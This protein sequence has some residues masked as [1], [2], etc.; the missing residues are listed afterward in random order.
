L[1]VAGTTN[2]LAIGLA[3]YAVGLA[4]YG[5]AA[6]TI[7]LSPTWSVRLDLLGGSTAPRRPV[8]G[9]Q[10]QSEKQTLTAWGAGFVAALAGVEATF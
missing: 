10:T 9:V 6:G 4:V 5:R 1:R 2:D 8:I 7:H 3:G